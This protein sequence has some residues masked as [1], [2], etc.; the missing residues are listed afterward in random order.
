[1]I[2]VWNLLAEKE[3]NS[4]LSL[5]LIHPTT[6]SGINV[7]THY[8]IESNAILV[9]IRKMLKTQARDSTFKATRILRIKSTSMM[10]FKAI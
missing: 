6:S 3:E 1:M 7:Y 2:T 9:E 4:N 8:E 5:D 10:S